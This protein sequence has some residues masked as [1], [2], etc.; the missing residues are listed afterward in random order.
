MKAKQRNP[1]VVISEGF[2]FGIVGALL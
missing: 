2:F 1:L